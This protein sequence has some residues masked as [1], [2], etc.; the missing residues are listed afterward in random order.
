MP[1]YIPERYSIQVTTEPA[2][3][4]VSLAEAKL[5][6]RVDGTEEND[7]ITDLIT[8]ARQQVEIDTSRTLIT[9]VLKLRMDDFPPVIYLPRPALISVETVK[10]YNTAGTL[11]TMSASEYQVDL[12]SFPGCIVP[13]P[14]TSWPSVE[15]DRINAVEV[16]YTAGYGATAASVPKNLKRAIL[17][18][19]QEG[20]FR[21]ADYEAQGFGSTGQA[22]YL[23]LVKPFALSMQ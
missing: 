21:R 11:T 1:F 9:T 22:G 12:Y 18:L 23:S 5:Q 8:A 15:T 17:M 3:E 19:V 4:P 10:Y 2:T 6:C 16:A 7:L 14:A 13:A 20:Y